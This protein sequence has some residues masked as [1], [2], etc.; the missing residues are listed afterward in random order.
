MYFLLATICS[1]IGLAHT[2]AHVYSKPYV[3]LGRWV[4]FF[5]RCFFFS[6]ALTAVCGA[7]LCV[8]TLHVLF[9]ICGSTAMLITCVALPFIDS[10]FVLKVST[11]LTDD[12]FSSSSFDRIFYPLPERDHPFRQHHFHVDGTRVQR[13]LRPSRPFY[14][15]CLVVHAVPGAFFSS[16]ANAFSF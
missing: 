1:A 5:F 13:L 12:S 11:R 15:Q 16:R 8:R 2:R 9:E 7:R 14:L 6:F 3:I 4:S 10:S